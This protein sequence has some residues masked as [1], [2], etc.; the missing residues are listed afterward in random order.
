MSYKTNR[1][2]A[3]ILV[4]IFAVNLAGCSG[5]K[6]LSGDPAEVI[7]S[8]EKAIN[9]CDEE[10]ILSLTTVEKGSSLY[11]DYKEVF[12]ADIYDDEAQRCFKAIAKRIKLNYGESDVVTGDGIVKIK[13]AFAIPDWEELFDDRSIKDVN[14]FLEKVEKAK[15]TDKYM[16]LR[17]IDTKDGLRLKNIDDIVDLFIFIGGNIVSFPDWDR[18]LPET[19]P[20]ETKPKE[21]EPSETKPSETEP[22]ETEPSETEP[23]TSKKPT[24]APQ[25]GTKDDLAKAYSDY[26]QVLEKN[27]E[28]IAWFEKNVSKDSCGLSDLN[29][30]GIPELF[31]FTQ[32]SAEKNFI[33]FRVYS[34]SPANKA[35]ANYLDTTLTDATSKISEFAVVKTP[36]GDI[37]TYKGFIDEKNVICYYNS[38][39]YNDYFSSLSYSGYIICGV[40]DGNTANAVCS[41]RGFDKYTSN[42]S[43]DYNEFLRVEK[44]LLTKADVLFCAKMLGDS[45][46][47]AADHLKGRNN[48]G[49]TYSEILK[50]LG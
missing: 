48:D 18:K 9:N 2:L 41:V 17:L 21:T 49:K 10:K 33:D 45:R 7:S 12:D 50:Q 36:D 16:T 47:T 22:S 19:K 1:I 24:K 37:V 35:T 6:K 27:A 34:Y 28:G 39:E 43:I 20:S 13:V 44:E 3:V 4:M 11:R 25:S 40:T 8:L 5:A 14:E 15:L 29:G 46:S 38:Y 32:S 26:K 30:D 31:F 23:S 42:S